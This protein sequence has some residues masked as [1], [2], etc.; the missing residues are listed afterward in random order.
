MMMGMHGLGETL[1]KIYASQARIIIDE[2][3]YQLEISK[4][5]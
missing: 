1:F 5:K 2:S 3:D 4:S